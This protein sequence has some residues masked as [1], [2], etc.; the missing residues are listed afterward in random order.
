M[1]DVMRDEY[2]ASGN[3]ES[4]AVQRA[5]SWWMTGDASRYNSSPTNSYT[6]NVLSFY[7]KRRNSQTQSPTTPSQQSTTKPS[8]QPP[9][10]Q[11]Q[12][13][14]EPSNQQPSGHL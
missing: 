9:T 10:T 11:P 7:Q 6:Q 2:K 12:K 1:R 8:A 14:P 3:N 4:V 13:A 5:A